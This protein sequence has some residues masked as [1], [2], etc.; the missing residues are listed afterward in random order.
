MLLWPFFLKSGVLAA[1]AC[2]LKKA[3]PFRPWASLNGD[4]DFEGASGVGGT[5]IRLVAMGLD[6]VG[7]GVMSSLVDEIPPGLGANE[8]FKESAKGA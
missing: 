3:P 8:I 4:W 6:G 1:A 5:T 7:V 2:A